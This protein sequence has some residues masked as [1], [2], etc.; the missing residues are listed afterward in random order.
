MATIA[1][2]FERFEHADRALHE[3]EHLCYC[4]SEFG[5]VVSGKSAFNFI[6]NRGV[7]DDSAAMPAITG[8]VL[9]GLTGLLAGVAPLLIPGIGPVLSGGG[10]WR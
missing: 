2:L 7:L 4:S 9:G 5:A 3:L 6:E 10:P 8:A 1:G